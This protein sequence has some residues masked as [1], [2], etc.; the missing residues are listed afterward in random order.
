LALAS[1]EPTAIRKRQRIRFGQGLWPPRA[2]GRHPRAAKA[3][4][5]AAAG[6]AHSPRAPEGKGRSDQSASAKFLRAFEATGQMPAFF[7]DRLKTLVLAGILLGPRVEDRGL[8]R[9]R[10]R[11]IPTL[12]PKASRIA[13]H[14]IAR[15]IP[16]FRRGPAAGKFGGDALLFPLREDQKEEVRKARP[17]FIRAGQVASAGSVFF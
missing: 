2:P 13:T 1:L 9:R 7:K 14:R 11:K 12:A 5:R 4:A 17:A 15:S 8:A 6:R 16:E 10:R 3:V